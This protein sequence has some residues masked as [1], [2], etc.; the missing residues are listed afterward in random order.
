MLL[1]DEPSRGLDAAARALVGRAI[2]AAAT[3]GAAVLMA[4]HD[5]DFAAT[6]ATRTIRM[7]ASR[8]EPVAVTS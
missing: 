6:Y 2:V 3:R 1:I 4:T 5:E 7:A 8:I